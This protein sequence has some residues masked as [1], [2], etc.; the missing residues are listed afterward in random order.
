MSQS[1]ENRQSGIAG[2]ASASCPAPNVD[3][4]EAR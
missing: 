4:P 3:V 2:S 1:T